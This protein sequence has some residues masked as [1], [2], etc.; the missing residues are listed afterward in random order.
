MFIIVG[1]QIEYLLTAMHFLELK[2]NVKPGKE[3]E[4][5]QVIKDLIPQFHTTL[6][7]NVEVQFNE[8]E[9]VLTIKLSNGDASK[10]IKE[11]MDDK[12]FALL[13]GSIKVLCDGYSLIFP[14]DKEE[15]QNF[16]INNWR[17]PK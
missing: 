7:L 1:L 8:D 11:I 14:S 17:E 5:N 3:N 13:L 16:I 15:I 6:D 12:N 10:K 4:L 2:A 9:G